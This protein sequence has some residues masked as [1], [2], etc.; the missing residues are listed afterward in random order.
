MFLAKHIIASIGWGR[1]DA[2]GTRGGSIAPPLLCIPGRRTCPFL[3]A[4]WLNFSIIFGLSDT[5]W[6]IFMQFLQYWIGEKWR[7][8]VYLENFSVWLVHIWRTWGHTILPGM[9]IATFMK[10]DNHKK[11][12]NKPKPYTTI[13]PNLACL[14]LNL[15]VERKITSSIVWKL[16]DWK[17]NLELFH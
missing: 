1:S 9:H 10:R 15:H 12:C 4:G 16:P 13:I 6:L 5:V 11:S 14:L 17:F 7:I 2:P 8:S 3:S